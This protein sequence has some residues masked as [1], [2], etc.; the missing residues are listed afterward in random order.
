MGMLA[1]HTRASVFAAERIQRYDI[2]RDLP[3]GRMDFGDWEGP[4]LKFAP[5]CQ[6][7]IPGT[8]A[9]VEFGDVMK[10]IAP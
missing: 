7:P 10:G 3:H 6:V 8:R 2:D 1:L 4:L 9:P 5:A